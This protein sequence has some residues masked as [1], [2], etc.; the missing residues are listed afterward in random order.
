MNKINKFFN[1]FIDFFDF[2]NSKISKSNV[3]KMLLID[4]SFVTDID[5]N[6]KIEENNLFLNYDVKSFF[7][8]FTFKNFFKTRFFFLN[9]QK[10][11]PFFLSKS[12]KKKK[13]KLKKKVKKKIFFYKIKSAYLKKWGDLYKTKSNF[14][15]IISKENLNNYKYLKVFKRNCLKKKLKFVASTFFKFNR[16]KKKRKK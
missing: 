16:K 13:I 3:R 15:R 1:K 6:K 4:Q 10:N 8:I 14:F 12:K 7:K 5:K 9:F 2:L 11:F